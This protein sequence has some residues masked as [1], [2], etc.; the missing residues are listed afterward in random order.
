[1]RR[2]AKVD[3]PIE[4]YSVM[5]SLRAVDRS[6][7][8]L[9]VFDAVEGVTEQDK[10][11]VGYAHE[12]GKAV[13]LV[14][15]KWDLYEKDNSSTRNSAQGACFPAVCAGSFRFCRYQAAYSPSAGGYLLCCRA[16]RYAYRY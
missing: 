12:A 15:N 2:K 7:V 9:M 6:D 1:M 3:E 5:R 8:V 10:R 16:E 11:I 13:I 4:K 14:V